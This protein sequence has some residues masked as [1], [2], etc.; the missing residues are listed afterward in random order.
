MACIYGKA[1][2]SAPE[3]SAQ[4]NDSQWPAWSAWLAEPTA[5]TVSFK[6]DK[7]C[8]Q[9]CCS[10]V[11]C[12]VVSMHGHIMYVICPGRG[13]LEFTC[14]SKVTGFFK[15]CESTLH[16]DSSM[17]NEG[18][19]LIR[20]AARSQ[21]QPVNSGPGVTASQMLSLLLPS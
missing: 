4:T 17:L 20:P 12:Q 10:I 1:N 15:S 6:P 18:S 5:G 11:T 3:F 21:P 14:H 9:G 2:A 8:W 7:A 13:S 16:C 19:L